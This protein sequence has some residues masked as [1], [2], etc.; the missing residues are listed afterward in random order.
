[1]NISLWGFSFLIGI[2]VLAA[3]TPPNENEAKFVDDRVASGS[4]LQDKSSRTD[5]TMGITKTI[6]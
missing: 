3:C 1:M 4:W 5:A 2:L 6:V